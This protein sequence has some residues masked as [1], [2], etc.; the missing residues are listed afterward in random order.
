MSYHY[1]LNIEYFTCDF[2]YHTIAEIMQATVIHNLKGIDREDGAEKTAKKNKK[3]MLRER[4]LKRYINQ[5]R[6]AKS[7]CEKRI[8]TFGGPD[9]RAYGLGHGQP[10]ESGGKDQ[11]KSMKTKRSNSAKMLSFRQIMDNSLARSYFMLFLQ[12]NN[13]N[14]LLG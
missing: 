14:N 9:Y 10:F 2:R 7:L 11:V 13:S 6:V 8:R 5:C 12:R 3:E 1:S 4:N